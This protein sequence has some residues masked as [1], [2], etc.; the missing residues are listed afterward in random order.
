MELS[1]AHTG[2]KL[3]EIDQD[4]GVMSARLQWALSRVLELIPTSLD[5]RL[6]RCNRPNAGTPPKTRSRKVLA[7]NVSS[8]SRPRRYPP[9]SSPRGA[10]EFARRTSQ[11][12]S[13]PAIVVAVDSNPFPCLSSMCRFRC[14]RAEVFLETSRKRLIRDHQVVVTARLESDH[15][16]RVTLLA[17]CEW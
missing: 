14:V 2:S 1:N 8:A 9:W 15:G 16:R 6:S 3:L 12:S 5:R 17:A 10:F 7:T 11:V 4:R 13:G